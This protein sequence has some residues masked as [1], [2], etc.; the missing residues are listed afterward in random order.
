MLTVL[1]KK[2]PKKINFVSTHVNVK[3]LNKHKEGKTE[4]CNE[5]ELDLIFK[6]RFFHIFTNEF[7]TP[8]LHLLHPIL[9]SLQPLQT[10]Q[11][12]QNRYSIYLT[13]TKNS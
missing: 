13:N 6:S 9:H 7:F 3:H 5:Q 11:N 1:K 4:R 2:N 8:L 12:F 10:Q